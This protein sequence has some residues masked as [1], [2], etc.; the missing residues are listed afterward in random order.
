MRFSLPFGYDAVGKIDREL[1][2]GHNYRIAWHEL[3]IDDVEPVNAPVATRWNGGET[4]FLNGQ[5]YARLSH[6][7]RPHSYPAGPWLPDIAADDLHALST[8][9][10]SS[11]SKTPALEMV[12]SA[13]SHRQS[14]S[15]SEFNT[16]RRESRPP[17]FIWSNIDERRA[18]IEK[19]AETLIAIEDKVLIAVDEP[20]YR[21]TTWKNKI[22]I[23]VVLNSPTAVNVRRDREKFYFFRADRF[24]DAMDFAARIAKVDTEITACSQIEVLI[25]TAIKGLD[26]LHGLL[27][28]AEQALEMGKQYVLNAMST[29]QA[30]TWLQLRDTT[31]LPLEHLSTRE[32]LFKQLNDYIA[33]LLT[34]PRNWSQRLEGIC[35]QLE[36]WQMRPI[37]SAQAHQ[38]REDKGTAQG[39]SS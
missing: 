31:Q 1:Y 4:I 21:V 6:V 7:T 19:L 29:E 34:F 30:M 23:D 17:Q 3:E 32:V 13:F 9:D 22:K 38:C 15:F 28:A 37:T 39:P 14:C 16:K 18:E 27:Y 36:R 24:D 11:C 33:V 25:P 26:D 5:H 35:Q 10:L 12:I 2:D 20:I 8:L